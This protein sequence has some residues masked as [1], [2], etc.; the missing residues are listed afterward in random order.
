[1]SKQIFSLKSYIDEV[2]F[3]S[4]TCEVS[5]LAS[6]VLST[7][8]I[9]HCDRSYNSDNLLLKKQSYVTHYKK[10]VYLVSRKFNLFPKFLNVTLSCRVLENY[11][12]TF[13]FPQDINN[14]T[15]LNIHTP[16]LSTNLLNSIDT[17]SLTLFLHYVEDRIHWS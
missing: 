7:S 6:S 1:M 15:T 5:L 9:K 14:I 12:D 2:N 10:K 17:Q 4:R 8:P 11:S 13:K 3:N 16:T